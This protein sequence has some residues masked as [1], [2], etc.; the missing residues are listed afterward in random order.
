MYNRK[1]FG[2]RSKLQTG[3]RTEESFGMAALSII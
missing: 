3:G 1:Y 2:L